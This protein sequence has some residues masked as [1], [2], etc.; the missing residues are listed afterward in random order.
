MQTQQIVV[1]RSKALELYRAYKK[2]AH[3]STP[4]DREVM[5]AY[6][7]LSHGRLVIKALESV[8]TAGVKTEGVDAGFPKLALCRADAPTCKVEMSSDGG[9][10]MHAGDIEPRSRWRFGG[11]VVQSR[12]VFSFPKGTFPEPKRER[13]WRGEAITPIVPI[14]MR[15]KR[16]LSNYH[17]L[18]EAEWTKIAPVDPFL[19]RRIGKADLWLVVA[20]WEL[21]SIE[22]AALSA[23][24][25]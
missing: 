11:G 25:T 3:Y 4:I 24:I 8:A 9:A 12:N 1:D 18:F 23:R 2:H 21:T 13:R 14:H 16:G 10:T 6:Q 15:P 22:R 20:M 7:E 17:I 5:R 19:L